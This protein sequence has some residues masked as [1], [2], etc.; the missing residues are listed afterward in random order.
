[1][2]GQY[3]K[4]KLPW[5]VGCLL[6][7]GVLGIWSKLETQDR[8]FVQ[9]SILEEAE[10]LQTHLES[11]FKEQILALERMGERW[12]VAGG[13]AQVLWE[14]DA[15][16]YI[17]DFA[18]LQ[19]LAWVDSSYQ[20][21]W[22]IS[23]ENPELIAETAQ[24]Q[25]ANYYLTLQ[26]SYYR[27]KMT[28]TELYLLPEGDQG[29]LIIDPL[30]L[31]HEQPG[32]YS[33]FNGYIVALLNL[34]LFFDH[35]LLPLR[36]QHY[37][38]IIADQDRI[39]YEKPLS[40]PVDTDYEA[41]KTIDLYSQ[42]LQF[43]LYPKKWWIQQLHSPF[44]TQFLAGG[45]LTSWTIAMGIAILQNRKDKLD[46]IEG[47]NQQLHEEVFERK[48]AELKL[49]EREKMLRSFYNS[50]PIMMG[51]VELLEDDILHLSDNQ[52]TADF[53]GTTPE[54]MAN[55]RA[56]IMGA[57]PEYIQTWIGHY[58]E[59][60][61]TQK[62]VQ[63]EYEHQVENGSYFL[64][65]TVSFIGCIEP[66]RPRFCY[67]VQDI[68]DR[69]LAQIAL[70][71]SEKRFR[72]LVSHSPVGIFQTDTNGKCLY[73]NPQ[74]AEITG[75]YQPESYLGDAWQQALHPEDREMI[76]QEW[77]A[78]TEQE[79][80]FDLEYRFQKPDG[81]VV[82]V[83]GNAIAVRN[84]NGEIT[85]YFGTVTDITE[86]RKTET[87][88]RALMDAIP[89]LMLRLNAKGEFLD[90]M[91]VNLN[92][93]EPE[94]RFPG[95][96]IIK[97]L[98]QLANPERINYI[99]KTLDTQKIHSYEYEITLKGQVYSEECRLIPFD[100]ES[101]LAV[102][103]DITQRKEQQA[104][105]VYQLN[106]VLLLQNITTAIRQSLDIETIFEVAAQKIGQA[107]KVNRC[108]IHLY[109]SEWTIAIPVLAQY[110]QGDYASLKNFSV[111][112]EGNPH[113]AHLM[114]QE[115]AI[116]SDNVYTD[117]LLENLSDLCEE[118]QLKSMLTVGTFYQGKMNGVIG[119]HQCDR[120]RHWTKEEIE[121]IEALAA[122][123]GIAI[124]QAS[125]L[126]QEVRQREE[127]IQKNKELEEAKIIADSANRA[128]SEFLANMS[129]EI[130]TPMNAVL[131]F[132]E[133]LKPL[134]QEPIAQ[135]YLQSISASSKTLL[136]LIN[137]ILDLSKIEAGR[138][139]INPEVTNLRNIFQDVYHIFLHKAQV[140][141][142][143]LQIYLDDQLPDAVI[144]DEVRLR[145]ILFNVVGNALKFTASGRV[146]I[147][148]KHSFNPDQ[149]TIH[150]EISVRDTGIGIS[151]N[152]RQRIFDA[153]T[154]SQG[155]SNRQFGGTGLGLAITRRL[156]DMMGG[157]IE[158]ESEL[159]QGSLFIFRF[160]NVPISSSPAGSTKE[161]MDS[162]LN[163]FQPSTILVV[164][165]IESNRELIRGYFRESHHTLW[166]AEDGEKAIELTF[167]YLPDIILL[168]LRM[169]HMNGREVSE[170]L[171]SH[172]ETQDIP[173][174]MV[175]AS[176]EFKDEQ[177]L[178]AI[179]ERFVLKPVRK[180][181]LV[182]VLKSL[183]PLTQELVGA[184]E[185]ENIA[186]VTPVLDRVQAEGVSVNLTE[187]LE[188]L[189]ILEEQSWVSLCQ[190]LE[191]EEVEQFVGQLQDISIQ[192]SYFPLINY[193]QNLEQQL[194]SFDWD[195]IPKTVLEFKTLLENMAEEVQEF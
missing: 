195:I 119:L 113:M 155:Q 151:Q 40:Q 42:T 118:I 47:I 38:L 169:P 75:H 149:N 134:I 192:Y 180:V 46:L 85:G 13:T 31:E 122:Q 135:K 35:L 183:L 128:K 176:S 11:K 144:F 73:V 114:S 57:S 33:Q 172:E 159:G 5:L 158:L 22:S 61:E 6:S 174:V 51:V 142:I 1:M 84:D 87:T 82:W 148:S 138:L 74:W 123:V 29:F 136:S 20:I 17:Q 2:A 25:T 44:P 154:Q 191:I 184:S 95:M 162:D 8:Q 152:D 92:S 30:F 65:A 56:S 99:Q 83:W 68:S 97:L 186:S 89:D 178:K 10:S 107:F 177:K 194:D 167:Q 64:L 4:L 52:A 109:N 188:N 105:L 70:E 111:P 58:Q 41:I 110:W 140:Q 24:N 26:D 48:Q 117:P 79:R 193:I 131:G 54:A 168:D 163:Q 115:E 59:A 60:M 71:N 18:G 49:E 100:R 7:L 116:A 67:L 127:L 86:R 16:N 45:L 146:E 106:K 150:L 137:D 139:E 14:K 145:Q 166:F 182:K 143:T 90:V 63:F 185:S 55:Q 170:F 27:K 129:H 62:A 37:Q 101:V 190:T 171:K 130:R 94:N 103:R 9:D 93:L 80:P 141:G 124:A 3:F 147:T 165:D 19:A 78:S 104:A 91:N 126:K 161:D 96:H 98:P 39:I 132:T 53:F 173:I 23:P 21:R 66:E 164:D 156:V 77:V 175:T 133:L 189:R 50:S 187:L 28:L 36:H 32:E 153:F 157:T 69:K 76:F 88:N 179:C 112:V 181:D 160:P 43:R 81:Q 125:L 121:L 34:E 15:L 108:L 72:I 120:Y 12:E 102:I